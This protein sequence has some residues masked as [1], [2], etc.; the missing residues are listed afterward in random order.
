MITADLKGND[1]QLLYASCRRFF[2]CSYD[3][4]EY[5]QSTVWLK[6]LVAYDIRMMP[7]DLLIYGV[8]IAL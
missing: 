3:Q 5:N 7:T 2:L 8:D 4:Q 6:S 1:L